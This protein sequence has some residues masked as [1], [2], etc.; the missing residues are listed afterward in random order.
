MSKA[1]LNMGVR[2]LH[3]QLYSQGYTFRLFHPGWMKRR[4]QDGSLSE[5]AKYD[6][7]YIGNIAAKYFET[8]L[9]DEH[10]LVMVDYSG[11]EWTY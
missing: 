1:S 8:A 9:R 4:M 10:R 7:D 11:Y 6:P 2:I 3:N 5:N